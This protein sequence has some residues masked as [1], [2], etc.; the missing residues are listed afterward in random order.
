M[1]ASQFG[2]GAFPGDLKAV[3][4]VSETLVRSLILR[5]SDTPSRVP[6]S[7]ALTG[8]V[9]RGF[10]QS[11]ANRWPAC[12]LPK[13]GPPPHEP[14]LRPVSCELTQIKRHRGSETGGRAKAVP[15]RSAVPASRWAG[16]IKGLDSRRRSGAAHFSRICR[17]MPPFRRACAPR[18]RAPR[19][20]GLHAATTPTAPCRRC[21]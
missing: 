3:P 18:I 19:T 5:L 7:S 9:A 13:S 6:A 2:A 11:P 14:E 15:E 1:R 17:T 12:G 10:A 21:L 8:D 16:P 4:D 20:R